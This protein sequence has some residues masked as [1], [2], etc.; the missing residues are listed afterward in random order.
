MNKGAFR[1]IFGFMVL[2]LLVPQCTLAEDPA[3]SVAYLQDELERGQDIFLKGSTISDDLI[4]RNLNLTRDENNRFIIN[5]SLKF[6]DCEIKGN[7]SF[8][9]ALFT[10]PM[11]FRDTRFS[12]TVNFARSK[13]AGYCSF[14]NAE[15]Q[16][17]AIFD[18][19][20]FTK[21]S[22]F[23]NA[24]FDSTAS[25]K[26]AVF[27]MPAYFREAKFLEDLYFRATTFQDAIDFEEAEFYKSALFSQCRFNGTANYQTA[28]FLDI[29]G[30]D[31][32]VSNGE[33]RFVKSIFSADANF[34]NMS[35]RN[36]ATFYGSKF[37]DIAR[38][39]DAAFEK[40]AIF[41]GCKF[42]GPAEFSSTHFQGICIF[43]GIEFFKV[44]KF[45]NANFSGNASFFGSYFDRDAKFDGAVFTSTLNLSEATFSQLFLSWDAIKGHLSKDKKVNQ[46]LIDNYKSLGWIKDRNQCYYDYRNERRIS[47]E[48]GFS[49]IMDTASFI[50]WGYGVRP[51]NAIICILGIIILFGLIYKW[52]AIRSKSNISFKDALVLSARTLL[53]KPPG[54]IKVKGA[55][56]GYVM[57]IQK[58]IFGFFVALFI[59]FLNQEIQ[60]YFKPPS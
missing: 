7:L 58:A 25:L 41:T 57:W 36:K 48:W 15:F 20:N 12:G 18:G 59:V 51:F 56:A 55:Q 52:L 43:D 10:K 22:D 26:K 8:G 60:S 37:R 4:L 49:R 30:F 9:S 35:F 17:A 5:S 13:F 53:L 40:E 33:M 54:D 45:N 16:K 29:S 47:S 46:S 28:S 14:H 38:F 19:A 1:L 42:E 50:Y 39:T 24:R 6:V 23:I 34:D 3:I 44:V 21:D 31:D 32:A 27:C 2:V 11:I